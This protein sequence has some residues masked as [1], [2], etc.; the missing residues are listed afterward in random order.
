M[1]GGR[2]SLYELLG[3]ADVSWNMMVRAF[4]HLAEIRQDVAELIS[5]EGRYQGYLARQQSDID[6]LRKDEALKIPSDINYSKIGGLSIEMQQRL[7]KAMPET[8]GVA[9]RLPAMTPAALTA[10]IGYIKSK[11]KN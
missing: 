3:F 10:L 9:A 8:I 6:A 11:K 5:I 1:N 7:K 4:P 2:R